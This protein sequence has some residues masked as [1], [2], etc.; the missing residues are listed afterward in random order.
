MVNKVLL[1]PANVHITVKVHPVVLFSICDLYIRRSDKQDRVIGT[2]LGI[3]SDSVV[4]VKSCYA[5]PHNENLDQIAVDIAHHRTMYDLHQRVS[6]QEVV[7][8]WFSTGPSISNSDALI[9]DFYAKECSNPLYMVIDTTLSNKKFN[10]SAYVARTLSLSRSSG[11]KPLATEFME[12]PTQVLF[13][14][15]ERVGVELLR[16]GSGA[17]PLG[18]QDSLHVTLKHLQDLLDKVHRYVSEV[19]DGRKKGDPVVG[20]YLADTMAVV[21]HFAKETYEHLFNENVQDVML[22]DYFATL[23]RAQIALAEKLGTSQLPLL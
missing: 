18:D 15:A 1:C 3:V 21:P 4:D 2:L 10:I 16:S 23:L 6:P 20:R 13:A 7:V 5:V 11:E 14:D 19:V 17:K 22:V 12:V 8:G 9:Q